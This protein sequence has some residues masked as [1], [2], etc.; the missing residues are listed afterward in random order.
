MEFRHG[1]NPRSLA[2]WV[3]FERIR[4]I[5]ATRAPEIGASLM[6]F[7]V[8]EELNAIARATMEME[9][10]EQRH[11]SR[12]GSQSGTKPSGPLCEKPSGPA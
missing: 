4:R 11:R 2:R 8:D 12:N 6:K 3:A 1:I 9:S 5:Q 10:A 7:L